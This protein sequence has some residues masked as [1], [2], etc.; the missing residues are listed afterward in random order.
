MNRP[1]NATVSAMIEPFHSRRIGAHVE[2]CGAAEVAAVAIAI[3][4]SSCGMY[5]DMGSDAH[6]RLPVRA[7]DQRCRPLMRNSSTKDA[8]SITA[9]IAVA[10]A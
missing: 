7:S 8:T 3:Q 4:A 10:S 5:S 9:A 6:A 1:R 2:P